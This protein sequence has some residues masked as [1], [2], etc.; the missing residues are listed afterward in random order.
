[1]N[2]DINMHD[3]ETGIKDLFRYAYYENAKIEHEE[4]RSD[5][6]E[7]LEDL[8]PEEIL[9]NFKDL[10]KDLLDEKKNAKNFERDDMISAN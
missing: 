8:E 7:I 2:F 1:M 5:E 4:V 6:K 3:I 9:E 10:V